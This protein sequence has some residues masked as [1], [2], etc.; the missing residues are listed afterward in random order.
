[1]KVRDGLCIQRVGV[2]NALARIESPPRQAPVADVERPLIAVSE[3]DEGK[4]SRGR[5]D[6]ALLGAERVQIT[7]RRVV[8][9]QQQ[10]IAVVNHHADRGVVIRTA[11]SSGDIGGFVHG[12]GLAALR[13]LDRSAE[14]GEAG[15]DDVDG[16]RHQISAKRKTIQTSRARE[17]RTAQR[18]AAK[19]RATRRSRIAP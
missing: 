18:G 17:R 8:T 10:V 6:E 5:T 11:A 16:A 15:A 1:M 2:G 3:I 13:Q 12:N 14:P 7:E 4:L 9:R 19:P